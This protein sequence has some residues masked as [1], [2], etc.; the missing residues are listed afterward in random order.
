[1]WTL[2][3]ETGLCRTK[4][5]FSGGIGILQE[6]TLDLTRDG[7]MTQLPGS[8]VDVIFNVEEEIQCFLCVCI[9]TL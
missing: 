6:L 8:C 5:H 2:S 4:W 1:M 7:D 3:R 9:C